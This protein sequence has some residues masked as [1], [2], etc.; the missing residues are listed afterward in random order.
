MKTPQG[1]SD[2]KGYMTPKE[3]Q[4]YLNGVRMVRTGAK[5]FVSYVAPEGI[6]YFTIARNGDVLEVTSEEGKQRM[7]TALAKPL[8]GGMIEQIM[9]TVEDLKVRVERIEE[10]KGAIKDEVASYIYAEFTAKGV[11][12]GRD[13]V[14]KRLRIKGIT[15]PSAQDIEDVIILAQ[16]ASKPSGEIRQS[17]IVVE[18]AEK[19]PGADTLPRDEWIEKAKL[20]LAIGE[21]WSEVMD[22]AQENIAKM[23]GADINNIKI[24]PS[25]T[26][27]FHINVDDNTIE[28]SKVL[29]EAVYSAMNADKGK[30][31]RFSR[32]NY[33]TALRYLIDHEIR[34]AVQGTR[35]G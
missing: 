35:A 1:P 18:V 10:G 3:L 7:E 8:E 23:A 4:Q 6:Q 11:E 30:S 2:L 31:A 9:A 17:P 15:Q 24:S 34:H 32:E 12:A 21:M 25:A 28:V 5:L 16:A 33:I 26:S 20:D 29:L 22:E 19:A 27:A 14:A 13:E